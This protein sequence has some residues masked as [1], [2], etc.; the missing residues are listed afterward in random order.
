MSES[1]LLIASYGVLRRMS[2]AKKNVSTEYHPTLVELIVFANSIVHEP[3]VETVCF[4]VRADQF[5]AANIFGSFDEIP[6]LDPK[7]GRD[8]DLIGGGSINVSYTVILRISCQQQDFCKR[9]HIS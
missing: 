9:P 6:H 4:E 7:L 8:G 1:L 2:F 5:K 3:L